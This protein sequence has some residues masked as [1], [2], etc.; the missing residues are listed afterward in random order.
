[1]TTLKLRR[2]GNSLGVILPRD[3]TDRLHGS[4]GDTVFVTNTPDGI[5]LTAHDPDFEVA[6]NAFEEVRKEYRNAFRKLSRR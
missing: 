4:T 1:M 3:V 5:E 6:M 2:I